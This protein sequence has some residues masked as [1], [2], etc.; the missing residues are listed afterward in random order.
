MTLH[1]MVYITHSM[2]LAAIPQ[3]FVQYVSVD[4]NRP[5]CEQQLPHERPPVK[6]L[7]T[8]THLVMS[9]AT[10]LV[11][12]VARNFMYIIFTGTSPAET[13]WLTLTD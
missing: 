7:V 6:Y 3:I 1:H 11:I 2:L 12:S 13:S 10:H 4:S 5:Y 8:C 9:T